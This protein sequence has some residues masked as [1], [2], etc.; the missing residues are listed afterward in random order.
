MSRP[1]IRDRKLGRE[2]AMGQCWQ[3]EGLIEIDPRLGAKERLDTLIHEMLHHYSPSWGE[4]RVI[5][6]AAEMT[7]AL[8]KDGYRR[9]Q[10]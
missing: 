8:W 5:N 9:I 4:E 6:T 1:V 10:R 3:G 2:K 7:N